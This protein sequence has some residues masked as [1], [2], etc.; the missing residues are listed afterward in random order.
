[1]KIRLAGIIRE[2][3]V[4]GP[5]IRFV[6]FTQGCPHHCPGC[7]NPDTHPVDGG[8][9]SDT[10]N[11]LAEMD[12]NPLLQGVTLSGG[13]PFLQP[14]PLSHLV[15]EANKR[16]LSVI[17]YTGFVME[18][19]LLMAQKDVHVKALLEQLETLVDGRFEI[20]KKNLLLRFRGSENQRIIDPAASLLQN[21]A[22]EKEDF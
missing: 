18:E 6:V 13:E 21:K 14:E 3:I 9:E 20:S 8:Y 10:E 17:A 7:H 16:G 2:S 12:K 22:V 15:K 4:D 5:G 19:L 1:M 11:L